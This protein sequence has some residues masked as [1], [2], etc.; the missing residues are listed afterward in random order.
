MGWCY[1]TGRMIRWCYL[2]PFGGGGRRNSLKAEQSGPHL[3]VQTASTL[4]WKVEEP[5]MARV[6]EV[7]M[8][9]YVSA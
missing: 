5:K 9:K 6:K 8:V 1:L 7:R 4:R 3:K 2:T